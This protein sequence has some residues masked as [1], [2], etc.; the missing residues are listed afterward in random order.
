[1]PIAT[2]TLNGVPIED[3]GLTV[4]AMQGWITIP[5]RQFKT[6]ELALRDGSRALSEASMTE[7]RV[8]TLGTRLESSSLLDRRTKLNTL[9]RELRGK[10]E[11]ASV[12]DPTKVCYGFIRAMP[13][14]QFGSRPLAIVQVNPDVELVCHDPLWY[15]K[16]PV[17]VAIPAV[18]TPVVLPTGL[19]SA[20]MRRLLIR[21]NGA[22]TTPLT[23]I[24]KH[25]GGEI[26]RMAI[27]TATTSSEYLEIDCD[28][29]TITKYSAGVGTDVTS[30]LDVTHDFFALDPLD[31][32][33]LQMDKG[34]ADV[35]F[36]RAYAA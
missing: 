28:A 24:L 13:V 4:I 18:N 6:V 16:E 25:N 15:D 10:L 23:L 17:E 8:I 33:T 12:E 3:Y 9:L 27:A 2:F 21:A 1:M 34:T 14:T 11:I 31:G 36:H 22:F 35:E 5:E 29:Y 20:R 30:T 32:L 19:A 7:P 26:A